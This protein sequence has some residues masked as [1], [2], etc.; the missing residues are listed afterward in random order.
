[1]FERLRLRWLSRRVGLAAFG[2]SLDYCGVL[3]RGQSFHERGI[4]EALQRYNPTPDPLK[5]S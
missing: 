3:E 5:L 2:T 4:I 1:M